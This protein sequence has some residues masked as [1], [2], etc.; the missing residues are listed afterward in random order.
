MYVERDITG[1]LLSWKDYTARRP[2]L[3]RGPRGVGKTRLM[4][5]F[6]LRHFR[7]TVK[8]DFMRDSGTGRIFRDAGSPDELLA[9]LRSKSSA[10]IAPGETLIILDEIQEDGLA[11]AKLSEF[12]C[13]FENLHILAAG[14]SSG[15][16][17]KIPP[18][19]L[20]NCELHPISFKEYLRSTDPGLFAIADEV[21]GIRPLPIGALNRINLL[22]KNY[23]F[24]G[25]YPKPL[26][27]MAEG[28][29]NAAV[30]KLLGEILA[31]NIDEMMRYSPDFD[32]KILA[33]LCA[34]LPV[35]SMKEQRRMPLRHVGRGVSREDCIQALRCMVESGFVY[36][37]KALGSDA[38]QDENYGSFR[39]FCSDCGLLRALTESNR[40][41]PASNAVMS[42]SATADVLV[43]T[44]VFQ[45][46]A[47]IEGFELSRY[48]RSDASAALDFLIGTASGDV[49]VE[50]KPMYRAEGKSLREYAEKF[51]PRLQL[52]YS[53]L[54]L[55]YAD[56]VR[57]CPVPLAGWTGK[58][59]KM[60]D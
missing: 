6:G 54:N 46:V 48:W 5:E 29:D 60:M 28:G 35:L 14:T 39:L 51:A 44:S 30:D 42:R 45:A 23:C 47:D 26:L 58:Y 41:A 22:H 59:L 52:R 12:A 17:G 16:S 24:S 32:G 33:S 57:N 27:F 18:T 9:A 10:P 8:F 53:F 7:Y 31:S 4:E 2:L 21:A 50:I 25:G 49:P 1:R 56:G 40:T 55:G 15:L 11:L 19:G 34:A 36:V 43:R 37:L 38:A 20:R 13:A 3:I